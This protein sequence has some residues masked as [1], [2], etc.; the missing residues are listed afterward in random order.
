MQALNFNQYEMGS[1]RSL[2]AEEIILIGGADGWSDAGVAFGAMGASFG[3][4]AGVV[5]LIPGGQVAGAITGAISGTAFG[6]E[7]I[8][9]HMTSE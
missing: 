5:S 7:W 1:V 4:V 2:S 9:N 6:V 3:I 8:C